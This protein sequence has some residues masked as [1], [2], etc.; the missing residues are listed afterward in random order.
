MRRMCSSSSSSSSILLLAAS[1]YISNIRFVAHFWVDQSGL[2]LFLM[3]PSE[4]A[5]ERSLIPW[6][7]QAAVMRMHI[8]P[9][10]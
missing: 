7:F 3:Q 2:A 6:L 4:Q 10:P 8:H 9:P 1:R 5:K